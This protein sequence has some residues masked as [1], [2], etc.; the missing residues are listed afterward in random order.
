MSG[1]YAK[2]ASTLACV[3]A[4]VALAVS[5]TH[6]G[7]AGPQGAPGPRGGAAVMSYAITD[8]NLSYGGTSTGML[9]LMSTGGSK[10]T[11]YSTL[12]PGPLTLN[13]DG[14]M[15][16]TLVGDTLRL[17][18]IPGGNLGGTATGTLILTISPTTGDLAGTYTT[19]YGQ[20]GTETG[21]PVKAPVVVPV[22]ALQSGGS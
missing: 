14:T 16:G 21:V 9:T 3:I 10:V 7:P 13:G 1:G 5:L 17:S 12:N 11:G 19:S 8:H 18:T 22:P 6:H 2:V 15:A 20:H 4:G